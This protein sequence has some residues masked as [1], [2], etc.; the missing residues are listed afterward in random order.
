M[1]AKMNSELSVKF[2]LLS[3][4]FVPKTEMHSISNE[5]WKFN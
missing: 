3:L 2:T 1:T 5:A 4:D